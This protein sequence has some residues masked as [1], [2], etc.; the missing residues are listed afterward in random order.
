MD[1]APLPDRMGIMTRTDPKADLLV[2]LQDAREVLLWKLEGLSE[3]DV[4]RPMTPSGTNLLG[5]VKHTAGAEALYFGETF[6]RPFDGP[7]LW[8]T[9]S[10]EANADLWATADETR[11][12]IVGLY[13]QVWAHSDKTIESLD[14][15]AVGRI[16]W[17]DRSEVTLHSSLV[18]M[19]AETDRHAGHA[20]VIRELIDGTAGLRPGSEAMA[21]GDAAW[22]ADHRDR[23]ERVARAAGNLPVSP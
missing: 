15:D 16:P 3:Y 17:G 4:R 18:H 9:G 10:A 7:P 1:S 21:P 5:L 13:R 8:I 22:W 12:H 6:G 23:L 20:D 2:Y 14:L 19:I 11:E